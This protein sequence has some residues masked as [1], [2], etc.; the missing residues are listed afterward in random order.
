VVRINKKPKFNFLNYQS[1]TIITTLVIIIIMIYIL[2]GRNCIIQAVTG[3]PCPACGITR[4]FISLLQL[5][6]WDAMMYNP[7][8]LLLPVVG[9]AL[10]LSETHKFI[11]RSVSFN[12]AIII[13][14]ALV[15][16]VYIYRMIIYFPHTTPMVYWERSLLGVILRA[17]GAI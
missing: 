11:T 8:I 6:F 7:L 2:T 4:A 16:G 15:F 14:I 13:M 9:L 17:A 5:N 1:L 12:I 10:I 3:M